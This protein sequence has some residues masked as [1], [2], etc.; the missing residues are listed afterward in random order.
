MNQW[1]TLLAW[2]EPERLLAEQPA[3]SCRNN[4]RRK[5]SRSRP[6]RPSTIPT[7]RQ[8]TTPVSLPVLV[9]GTPQALMQWRR[10][11]RKRDAFLDLGNSGRAPTI[12]DSCARPEKP[13]DGDMRACAF[14]PARPAELCV[15]IAV[16]SGCGDREA[17]EPPTAKAT[18]TATGMAPVAESAAVVAV[19]DQSVHAKLRASDADGDPLT[20]SIADAPNH[21]VV[22]LDAVTGDFDLHPWRTTS[23]PT[24]SNTASVTGMGTPPK[25]ASM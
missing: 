7:A 5:S 24:R 15:M 21:V 14:P 17:T 11:C 18:V 16:L 12:L 20:F 2:L 10:R 8:R 6:R 23:V 19:E 9:I 22:T 3:P 4:L 13:A 1:E 25:R